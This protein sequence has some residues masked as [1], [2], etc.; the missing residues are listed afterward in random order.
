M[1]TQTTN[2]GLGKPAWDDMA[3]VSVLNNNSDII[4]AQMYANETMAAQSVANMADAYDA[5]ATYAEGDYCTYGGKLYQANTDIS[6]AEAFDATH[7]DETTAAEHFSDGGGGGGG[8]VNYSTTEQVIGTWIDGKPLYSICIPVTTNYVLR[9]G[10]WTIITETESTALNMKIMVDFKCVSYEG[11]YSGKP[12]YAQR[13]VDAS[14]TESLP[15]RIT[16]TPCRND[17]DYLN[18][19]GYIIIT[20]TKTTD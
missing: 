13:I 14:V 2:Y 19:G 15:R 7:W 12:I 20:Y 1:A 6:V 11:I 5:T 10:Q 3:D 16:V 4:D 17:D 9:N 18:S 8:G